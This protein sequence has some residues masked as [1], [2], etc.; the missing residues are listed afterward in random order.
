MFCTQKR[1][2]ALCEDAFPAAKQNDAATFFAALK[3]L[4]KQEIL[5]YVNPNRNGEYNI[6]IRSFR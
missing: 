6:I 4:N 5:N 1:L 3:E 2:S